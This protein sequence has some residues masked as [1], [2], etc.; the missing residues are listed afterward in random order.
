MTPATQLLI[1]FVK[2]KVSPEGTI[3]DTQTL[4]EVQALIQSFAAL[5]D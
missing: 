1:S 5:L 3:T 2:T 4:A